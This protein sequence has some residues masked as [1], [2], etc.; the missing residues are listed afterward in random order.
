VVICHC[1]RV[2]STVIEA[3]ILAG[4][5]NLADVTAR[6]RA[7]GRCGSCRPTIEAL[8]VSCPDRSAHSAASAA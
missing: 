5:T 6:C 8:L 1:E 7:A 2:S 3:A 4:A